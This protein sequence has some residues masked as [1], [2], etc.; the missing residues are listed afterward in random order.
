ML[1]NW[2]W[3][4]LLWKQ[5]KF[6][7]CIKGIK[8]KL[9]WLFTVPLHVSLSVWSVTHSQLCCQHL[10]SVKSDQLHDTAPIWFDISSHSL[11][12]SLVNSCFINFL[13]LLFST[14]FPSFS[15]LR[16]ASSRECVYVLT[17]LEEV[18][19]CVC[20]CVLLRAII[21]TPLMFHWCSVYWPLLWFLSSSPPFSLSRL[22]S[23]LLCS[24]L[25]TFIFS[26]FALL[27]G[28]TPLNVV[29]FY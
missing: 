17:E 8:F 5:W 18:S 9:R 20:V 7:F 28:P 14:F 19:V 1:V 23:S 2:M 25:H 16:N 22:L 6:L 24:F 12:H 29:L 3:G 11:F 21:Q 26:P 15:S 4:F 13:H 27:F 10:A